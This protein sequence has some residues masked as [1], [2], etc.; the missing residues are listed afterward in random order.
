MEIQ[1]F[2]GADLSKKTIDLAIHSTQ[3]HVQIANTQSGFKHLLSWIR[4]RRIE[5]REVH[6]IMEHTGLYSYCFEAFLSAKGIVF[7]KVPALAVKR[8]MGIIR[9]KTDK[10][11]AFRI[12]AYG[13]EKKDKLQPT[14]M[15]EPT[16][17]E[18]QMLQKTRARLVSQKA[19]LICAIKE[20]TNIGITPKSPIIKSQN[21]VIKV[22]EKEI[23]KLEAKI[24]ELIE[25]SQLKQTYNLLTSIKGVGRVVAIAMIIK[26][27]NF[28][29]FSN[30]RKFACFCGIAPFDYSSGTS[31]RKRSRVSHLADK[32]MKCL[33]DLSSKTAIQHDP[34]LKAY[35]IRRT[36]Q[37]KPK[38]STINIVRNKIVQRM[39]AVIKRQT[40]FIDN[41][42]TNPEINLVSC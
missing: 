31:I 41:F 25:T 3:Q 20:Y 27:N 28:S 40:T 2:I 35:Y 11:D 30:A 18:L 6:I 10:I 8:S 34:E 29:R 13:F 26:T 21:Q 16:I 36:E 37:G 1:Q 9:G 33:L 42:L 7:T 14:Q 22:L 24:D 12:A 15:P 38:R 4:S 19:S 39:F 32:E 17:V 5:P 23:E